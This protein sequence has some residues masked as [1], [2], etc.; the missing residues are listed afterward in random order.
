MQERERREREERADRRLACP[1]RLGK[2]SLFTLLKMTDRCVNTTPPTLFYSLVDEKNDEPMGEFQRALPLSLLAGRILSLFLLSHLIA[3]KGL[4]HFLFII[5]HSRNERQQYKREEEDEDEERKKE[6]RTS[7]FIITTHRI[8]WQEQQQPPPRL[9]A[10]APA[11]AAIEHI[12]YIFLSLL[13][14]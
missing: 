10:A 13:C 9:A 14:E 4:S 1:L 2:S 6:E 8:S 12:D 5:N 3:E 11:S 7:I